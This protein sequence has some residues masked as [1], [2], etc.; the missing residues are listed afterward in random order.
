[1]FNTMTLTKTVGAICGTLLIF[2]FANWGADAIYHSGGASH[3]GEH[4]QAYIIDTGDSE[5]AEVE[6]VVEVSF[7]VLLASADVGK[8]E[9][10]FNKCKACHKVDGSNGT[11]PHLDGVVD[12]DIASVADYGF[13]DALASLDGAW[14]PDNLSGFLEAPKEYAPGTKMSFAGL[15]KATDRADLVAYLQT[16]N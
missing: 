14:T 16:L 11:G 2:L 4:A 15:S 13:S 9:K 5:P 12:R 6:E 8:G 1:M 3:D 7:D 10:V